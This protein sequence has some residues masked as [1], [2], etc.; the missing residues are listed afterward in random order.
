[1]TFYGSEEIAIEVFRLGV[2]DYVIKPFTDDELLEA[3]EKA[4][5]ETRLRRERDSLQDRLL[6]INR[7]LH[8]QVEDLQVLVRVGKGMAALP[9]EANLCRQITEAAS[10]FAQTDRV[11]LL[12]ASP[13]AGQFI[14]RVEKTPNGITMGGGQHKHHFAAQAAKAGRTLIGDPE[15]DSF[16]GVFRVQVAVPIMLGGDALGVIVALTEAERISDHH[17]M[18]LG[19]LADYAALGLKQPSGVVRPFRLA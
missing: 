8:Q 7:E 18:L 12:L 6:G 3:I 10:V 2:K 4:L 17:V 15:Y 14:N 19:A 5:T 11:M 9:D 1:M 16:S 13:E